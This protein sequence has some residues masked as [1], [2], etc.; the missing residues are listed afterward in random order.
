LFVGFA[1]PFVQRT[2][3]KENLAYEREDSTPVAFGVESLPKNR[4]SVSAIEKNFASR[5]VVTLPMQHCG[6]CATM[7]HQSAP[8]PPFQTALQCASASRYSIRRAVR[9]SFQLR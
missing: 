7:A 6:R 9:E 2:D 3:Q 8:E 4:A 5:D 1:H